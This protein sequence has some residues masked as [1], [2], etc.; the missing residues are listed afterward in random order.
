CVTLRY[1]RSAATFLS[2][3]PAQTG[4]GPRNLY[5][6]IE[7]APELVERKGDSEQAAEVLGRQRM[8]HSGLPHLLH[9]AAIAPD[10][11][12]QGVALARHI[13]A[14]KNADN[15][16]QGAGPA[17]GRILPR[18]RSMLMD[19]ID[20]GLARRTAQRVDI[21]AHPPQGPQLALTIRNVRKPGALL[22]AG[23]LNERR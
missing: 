10:G 19:G 9:R 2:S 20:A 6:I 7:I 18:R 3:G 4:R 23:L 5:Q 11:G 8:R 1:T 14:G 21:M 13:L 16:A 17:P 12:G 15:A 22:M